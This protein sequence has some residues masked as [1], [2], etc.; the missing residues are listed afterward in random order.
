MADDISGVLGIGVRSAATEN[1]VAGIKYF[2]ACF[3]GV[4]IGYERKRYGQSARNNLKS[5]TSGII[6]V[7][8]VGNTVGHRRI[9]VK[10]IRACIASE[11]RQGNSR[12]CT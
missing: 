6:Y 2:P 8:E 12:T 1:N 11:G 5:E 10:R 7:V 4:A 3:A 9:N